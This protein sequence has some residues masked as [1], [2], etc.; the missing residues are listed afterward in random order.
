MMEKLDPITI[1]K[2]SLQSQELSLL[3]VFVVFHGFVCSCCL[4][5]QRE[6]LGFPQVPQI[7]ARL[8]GS[9]KIT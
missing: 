9:G 2:C 8:L 1:E 6:G 7:V 3:L 4:N 5:M